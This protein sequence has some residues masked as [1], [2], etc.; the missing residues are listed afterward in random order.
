MKILINQLVGVPYTEEIE[1]VVKK[2]LISHR[3]KNAQL[4]IT[5]VDD[6]YIQKLNK[7]YRFIDKPTDVLSFPLTEGEL[8]GDVFISIPSAQKNARR[9]QH[10]LLAEL[11][12][13][14]L[15]GVLHLLGYKHKTLNEKK[16]MERKEKLYLE[17]V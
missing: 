8:L 3:R 12:R 16:I 1:K 2:A 11:K 15:H 14:A 5:F 17:G 7:K 10:A 4:S 6:A 9:Y 13:L